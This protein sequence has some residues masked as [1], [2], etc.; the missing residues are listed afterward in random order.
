M[1]KNQKKREQDKQVAEHMIKMLEDFQMQM[2]SVEHKLTASGC[3]NTDR[4]MLAVQYMQE[5]A[6]C[7]EKYLKEGMPLYFP[8]MEMIACTLISML[9]DPEMKTI[10]LVTPLFQQMLL[11]MVLPERNP[12]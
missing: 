2:S 12:L 4:S 8:P 6:S 5:I 10:E 9:V 1:D 7:T 3:N 11:E